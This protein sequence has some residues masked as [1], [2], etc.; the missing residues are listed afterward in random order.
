MLKAFSSQIVSWSLGKPQYGAFAVPI[1]ILLMLYLLTLVTQV[2][3]L[4]GR[5]GD[6]VLFPQLA[7][8]QFDAR[9][10]A[11]IRATFAGRSLAVTYHNPNRRD[12]G[13]YHIQSVLLAG[14]AVPLTAGGEAVIP[15]ALLLNAETASELA[16]QVE[17]A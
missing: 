13:Q 14:Q 9:G 3:G 17:L 5:L 15:R 10:R 2:F 12:C 8:E 11:A 6:L 4:R 16:I 1:T 7:A